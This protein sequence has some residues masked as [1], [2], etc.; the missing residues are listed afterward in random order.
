MSPK[1]GT[2]GFCF[3]SLMPLCNCLLPMASMPS[4]PSSDGNSRYKDRAR[5]LSRQWPSVPT[6]DAV[7]SS[8]KRPEPCLQPAAAD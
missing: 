5:A 3:K 7:A 4:L 8:Y 2:T 6:I 1:P